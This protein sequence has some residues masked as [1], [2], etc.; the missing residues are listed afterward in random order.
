MSNQAQS[1]PIKFGIARLDGSIEDIADMANTVEATS[2]TISARRLTDGR[3]GLEIN[4]KSGNDQG[5]QLVYLTV[6]EAI[7]AAKLLADEAEAYMSANQ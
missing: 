3:I 5:V 4:R 1:Q 2:Y 6:H 7:V